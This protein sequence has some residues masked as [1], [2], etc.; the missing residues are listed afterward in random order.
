[1]KHDFTRYMILA[2]LL[3]TIAGEMLGNL[4]ELPR[5]KRAVMRILGELI[6]Q[7]AMEMRG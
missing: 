7:I 6:G 4:A 2:D 3:D 1:M 5:H